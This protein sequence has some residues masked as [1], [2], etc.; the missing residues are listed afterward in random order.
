MR[1]FRLVLVV[2]AG[3]VLELLFIEA[4]LRFKLTS[5]WFE[6]ERYHFVSDPVLHHRGLPHVTR[7]VRGVELRTNSLG[8]RG[9]EYPAEK[10]GDTFRIL[11]VGDSVVEGGG[12]PLEETIPARLQALLAAS[13]SGPSQSMPMAAIPAIRFAGSSISFA[14]NGLMRSPYAKWRAWQLGSVSTTEIPK[15]P[16]SFCNRSTS[17][18]GT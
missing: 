16:P 14:K 18:S 8:L 1:R 17:A 2:I 13:A 12:L 4:A 3:I 7:Q 9:R 6:N 10:D 15:R 5:P 11:M